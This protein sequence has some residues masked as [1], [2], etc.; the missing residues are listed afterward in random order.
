MPGPRACWKTPGRSARC[1][2]KTHLRA[3]APGCAKNY[4]HA[5]GRPD[6]RRPDQHLGGQQRRRPSARSAR[7]RSTGTWHRGDPAHDH[8]G[9][10]LFSNA[11]RLRFVLRKLEH[12]RDRVGC[13][14]RLYP[15]HLMHDPRKDAA[16]GNV[17]I[18]NTTYQD[19]KWVDAYLCVR[20][21]CGARYR[22]EE[23][24]SHYTWWGWK[25]L[26]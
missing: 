20:T 11:E 6:L 17:R 1:F 7:V 12:H 13:L 25:V 5:V 18:E 23:R 10:A 26:A 15:E 16:A 24:E 14:C 9:G 2:P 8:E 19:G 3:G 22:V 4:E 21:I